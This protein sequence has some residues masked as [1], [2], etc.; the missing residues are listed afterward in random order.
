MPVV[1]SYSS[2]KG[3]RKKTNQDAINVTRNKQGHCISIVC[4]GVSSH[5]NSSIS[6]NYIVS[7]FSKLWEKEIF[8]NYEDMKTWVVQKTNDF[9][10]L[11]MNKANK[12]NQKM[13]TTL[14]V[15][16]V[17]DDSLLVVNV[18]DSPTYGLKDRKMNILTKEDSFV[19]TLLEAGVITV[20]EAKNHPK[21]RTL[22]QAIG[23][24]EK[25]DLHINEKNMYDYD[26]I[27]SC[28]DGLITMLSQDE[29]SNI[30]YENDLSIAIEKLIDEANKKGGH[31][32]ISIS[33]MEIIK[34]GDNE[35]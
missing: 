7:E 13:A 24:S 29:I 21:R 2:D 20:E 23:I 34:G 27:L 4:D 18:G 12:K 33:I 11:I 30:I 1:Y 15:T 22:T 19:A 8:D 35:R 14:V 31:D 28:S 17:F 25:V 6:S 32:N 26:Y 5:K 9:N 10:H 3:L 16:V